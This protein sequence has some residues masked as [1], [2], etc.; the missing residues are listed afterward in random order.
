MQREFENFP[1]RE[2]QGSKE[3]SV[4][5]HHSAVSLEKSI[6]ERE[7]FV[8]QVGGAYIFPLLSLVK[9]FHVAKHAT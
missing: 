7:F 1:S 6:E 5:P 4:I 2:T 9:I 8:L 3:P